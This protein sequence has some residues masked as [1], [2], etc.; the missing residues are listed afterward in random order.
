[1]AGFWQ[2]TSSTK[3]GGSTGVAAWLGPKSCGLGR[4]DA[5]HWWRV[6]YPLVNGDQ[7]WLMMVNTGVRLVKAK[8]AMS[9]FE[10]KHR[11]EIGNLYFI[12]M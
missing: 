7:W 9:L 4:A 8:S 11:H 2:P 10:K 1:M 3:F 12:L 5:K 6:I